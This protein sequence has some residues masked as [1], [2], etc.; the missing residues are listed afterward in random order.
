MDAPRPPVPG[1][2]PRVVR[3]E[4]ISDVSVPERAEVPDNLMAAMLA[5]PV[6]APERL[7]LE[8]VRLCGP[9]AVR[10]ADQ[11]R[12]A[13]PDATI[14]QLSMEVREKFTR[15]SQVS[16]AATGALGLPGA[17]ADMVMVSWN[18]ARMIVYLAALH[19]LDPTDEERAAEILYF[20]GVHKA[21]NYAEN[22]IAVARRQAPAKTV[23]GDRSR[24]MMALT[25]SL[26]KMLGKKT[27][28]KLVTRA[29][30]FGAIPVSAW[31]NGRAMTQLADRVVAEYARRMG[32]VVHYRAL[33]S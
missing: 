12:R 9:Q 19:H 26:G 28:K 27:V 29:I 8:A 25:F 32:V 1:A 20:T 3:S 24:S 22:A 18:Q 7:A 14:A 4:V 10:W 6:H 11:T 17:V 15:L 13:R 30:P 16:G 33:K 31:S 21:I 5:D 2:Q 23:F